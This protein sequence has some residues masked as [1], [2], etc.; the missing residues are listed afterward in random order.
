MYSH[1]NYLVKPWVKSYPLPRIGPPFWK[2][3]VIEAH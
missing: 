1:A 3:V 2:D